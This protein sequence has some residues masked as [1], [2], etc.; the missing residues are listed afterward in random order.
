MKVIGIDGGG[1]GSWIYPPNI[2]QGGMAC[3]IIPQIVNRQQY[4]DLFVQNSSPDQ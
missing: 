2:L 1:G 4:F 3:V